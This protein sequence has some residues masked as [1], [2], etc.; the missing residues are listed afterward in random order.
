MESKVECAPVHR[1]HAAR[2]ERNM[3]FDGFLRL[4]VDVAPR[5]AGS[6]GADLEDAEVERAEAVADRL[7]MLAEAGVATE[8]Y[9]VRRAGDHP[10]RPQCGVAVAHAAA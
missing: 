1:K 6:V 5:L 3:R 8:V 10:R 4:H 2:L 7:E 9:P